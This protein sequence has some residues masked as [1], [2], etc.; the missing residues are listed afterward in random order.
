MQVKKSYNQ[1][2]IC[3]I[4]LIFSLQGCENIIGS[5]KIPQMEIGKPAPD[6][7]LQ[8]VSGKSW[9]LFDQKGKIVFL[10]FWAT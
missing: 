2:F 6:F 5:K 9:K 8:D 10:N 4:L 3:L 1:Q 7:V